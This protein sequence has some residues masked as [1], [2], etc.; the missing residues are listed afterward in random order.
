MPRNGL[1]KEK[2]IEAAAEWIDQWGRA[3]FSMRAL[4][5][6]LNVKT[7]SLYNHIDSMD[8][9]MVDV[10][11]YALQMQQEMEMSAIQNKTD[12]EAIYALAHAYRAF[13]KEH[14]ELYHLI[15]TTAV[16][17]GEKMKDVSED[18][19]SCIVEPFLK[20]LSHTALTADEKIHWQRILRGIVHGFV[21]E[22]DAGFFSHL[23]L[24]REDS[25]QR[26]IQ[27]YLDG[28]CAAEKRSVSCREV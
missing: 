25:F 20:V 22:E 4:A 16:S 6:S 5:D 11:I 28:L 18:I 13:A 10:C 15:M 9:L 3:A 1:T 26:A 23:P 12:T 21:S 14:R 8:A 19:S 7:A 2:V 24:D 17:C 27:C